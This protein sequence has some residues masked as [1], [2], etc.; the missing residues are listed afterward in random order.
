MDLDP[1]SAQGQRLVANIYRAADRMRELLADLAGAGCGTKPISE[2]CAIHDVIAAASEA[3]LPT[4]E[5]QGVQILYDVPNGLEISLQRSR[6]E[7]VFFNLIT[8][9]LEA[10]PRGGKIRI[11]AT[12]ANNRVLIAVEDTGPGVPRG[13]RERLFE[14]FVTAGKEHGLGLGLALSRQTMIDHGGD[15]WYEAAQG[16]RFVICLP[17]ARV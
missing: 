13:I 9:A 16:A 12:K 11:A 10:M 17:L 4:A 14:P 15:M 2:I 3:A 1:G 8:N 5:T 6:V 7:R